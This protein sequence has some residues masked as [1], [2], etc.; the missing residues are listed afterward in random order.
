TSIS[1]FLASLARCSLRHSM[2]TFAPRRLN[3]F[4]VS[5]PIPALAPVTAVTL[6]VRETCS[7][8]FPHLLL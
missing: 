8:N 5:A 4:T 6:P 3:S 7:V 1:F 2:Y